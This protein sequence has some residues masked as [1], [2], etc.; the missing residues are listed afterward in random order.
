MQLTR[1][2]LKFQ[3]AAALGQAVMVNHWRA[4]LLRSAAAAVGAVLDDA[5]GWP[6]FT[7]KAR[8]KLREALATI[9][10]HALALDTTTGV[11]HERN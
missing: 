4:A 1:P 2:V 9:T 3:Q 11:C 10:M 7:E 6:P 8:D 5:G